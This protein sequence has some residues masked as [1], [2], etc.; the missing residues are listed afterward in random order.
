MIRNSLAPSVLLMTLLIS[1][2][3]ASEAASGLFKTAKT[4]DSGGAQA[5]SVAVADVNG[6]GKLDLLVADACN[7][8]GCG[9][10]LVAVL[11]GNGDGTFQTAQTYGS[12]GIVASAV[13]LADVNGDGKLDVIVANECDSLRDCAVPLISNVGV[14]LGNGDGSL[15]PV[16]TYPSGGGGANA[17]SV[18][19]VN[20]DHKVDLIVLH[21]CN[22]AQCDTGVIGVL[23]GNGDGTFQAPL[24][25]E[26]GGLDARS[27]A[28]GDANGDGKLDL[29]VTH[30]CLS[31]TCGTGSGVWVL[32][33]KG[34]GTFVTTNAYDSG[35]TS[36][37]SVAAADLNGDGKLDLLVTSS[38]DS[39]NQCNHGVV[40]I[41]FGNGDGTFHPIQLNATV[42]TGAGAVDVADVNRD[43]KPDI[44]VLSC[45]GPHQCGRGGVNVLFG[46]G[47]GSF[48][49]AQ[50]TATGAESP[51]SIVVAD[52]NGDFKPDLLIANAFANGKTS[53]PGFVSVLLGTTRFATTTSLTSNPNPSLHGQAV[54]LTATVT[55]SGGIPPTGTV[56]FKNGTTGLGSATLING[57]ATLTRTNL[58]VGSLSI[59]AT[60]NG[61]VQSNKSTS[62]VLIQVVN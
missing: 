58:P 1:L 18:S 55:S 27:M 51:G 23:R 4:Y 7:P 26:S 61:D 19:D 38:C 56:T 57:V 20:G 9:Q 30:M 62:P 48:Q 60:Y 16:Q 32:L 11:L 34:D 14:L 36:A 47:D 13:A 3:P 12:G 31:N 40:G 46:N 5:E 33:G 8:P 2:T 29:F 15:Q 41:L 24:I 54:T 21:K 28:A 25:S 59:T 50:I 45:I 17:L 49:P 53:G 39:A 42:G 10:G 35:T 44:L 37:S 6:D 52:V 22:N 43:G